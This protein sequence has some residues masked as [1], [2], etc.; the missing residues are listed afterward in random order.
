MKSFCKICSLIGLSMLLIGAVLFGAGIAAGARRFII[1]TGLLSVDRNGISFMRQTT[2]TLPG[3]Q[4][5]AA[6]AVK[7]AIQG[8]A[9]N[10]L[11]DMGGCTVTVKAGDSYTVE[12]PANMELHYAIEGDTFKV[13]GSDTVQFAIFNWGFGNIDGSK[14]VT[15]TVPAGEYESIEIKLGAGEMTIEQGLSCKALKAEAGLG[16]L[17]IKGLDVSQSCV[18]D[19]G[20]GQIEYTGK[21]A[22]TIWLKCGMGTLKANLTN[23]RLADYETAIQCGMGSVKVGSQNFGGMSI[24]SVLNQGADKKMNIDCGMGNVKVQE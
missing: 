24:D 3:Y 14:Q 7:H 8:E 23:T 9:K 13:T 16:S 6:P 5:E 11:L 4:G 1:P 20:M 12:A 2:I 17:H 18:L 15:V 22:G 19:C 10:I 21:G